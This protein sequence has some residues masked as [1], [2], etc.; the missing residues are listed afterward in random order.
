MRDRQ[1]QEIRQRK[2]SSIPQAERHF[3]KV[4][5]IRKLDEDKKRQTS[6]VMCGIN[7]EKIGAERQT[8]RQRHTTGKGKQEAQHYPRKTN[9]I[10]QTI[11]NISSCKLQCVTLYTTIYPS[12]HTSSL[13]A[14]SH[15]SGSRP[16]A[17]ATPS[18]LDPH[19]D[20]SQ[21]SCCCPVSWR[22][23]SFGSVEWAS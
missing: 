10:K 5:E 7:Q 22:P 18:I 23:C 13:I 2:N 12:I 16:L 6:G 21:I 20:S 11:E 15:W 4:L 3:P 19:Q 17:S 9:K 14:T 8:C 1:R